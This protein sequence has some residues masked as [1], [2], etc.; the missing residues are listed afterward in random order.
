MT[1]LGLKASLFLFFFL[2]GGY[3]VLYVTLSLFI[4]HSFCWT[5]TMIQHDL[6]TGWVGNPRWSTCQKIRHV[7]EHEGHTT[8]S[9]ITLCGLVIQAAGRTPTPLAACQV[10]WLRCLWFP[11]MGGVC[12]AIK[13]NGSGGTPIA[14]STRVAELVNLSSTWVSPD[15]DFSIPLYCLVLVCPFLWLN[16]QAKRDINS[17]KSAPPPP[18][19]VSLIENWVFIECTY[20]A[21]TYNRKWMITR[22]E[23]NVRRWLSLFWLCRDIPKCM[24]TLPKSCTYSF[25]I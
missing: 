14:G 25:C 11:G 2:L 16:L 1:H 20:R 7:Y 21:L 5:Q 22:S 19:W 18:L 24:I 10:W 17:L 9:N 13:L 12:P 15:L 8:C 3:T 4:Y 23:F 6:I